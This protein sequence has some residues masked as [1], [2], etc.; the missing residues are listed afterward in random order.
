MKSILFGVRKFFVNPRIALAFLLSVIAG[1][2]NAQV[3]LGLSASVSPSTVSTG[4]TFIYTLNYQVS[5]FTTNGQNVVATLNLPE[6]LVPASTSPF[7]NSVEFDPSQV[8]GVT[9]NSGQNAIT[10]TFVNPIPA[11][12]TGQL[13]IRFRYLNGSTPNG[14]APDLFASI[15]ADN[16]LNPGGGTGPVLSN[17]LNVTAT[18]SNQH[19]ISKTKLAG[20]AIDNL[21]IY[22]INVS[23]SSPSNGSLITYQPVLVDTLPLGVEFVEATGFS[24]STVPVYNALTRTV[25]WTWLADSFR[26]N[27]SSSAY[28]SVRYTSPTFAVSDNVCNKI[29]LFGESPALPI[30]SRAAF[31]KS[32]Q[33]CFSIQSPSPGVSCYGGG[34]TAATAHW[35]N[36]HI[37]PGTSC[38][39]FSNGWYNSGNTEV[40]S[41]ELIYTVDKSIDFSTIRVRPVVD[42]FDSIAEASIEVFYATNLNGFTSAGTFLS[43]AI[44]A[45]S[46]GTLNIP[47]SLPPGE[48]VTQVKFK[49]HGPL[50]IGGSQDLSYCGDSRTAALGAKDGSP[51][52]E[53]TTYNPSNVGDDG[54][55]V[56]NNSTGSF[57]FNN[58]QTAYSA[59]NGSA[60]IMIAQ[61]VFGFTGKS[62]RNS[63]SSLR[64]SDTVYYEFSTYLGGNVNSTNVTITDTLDARLTYVPGTSFYLIDNTGSVITPTI[65]TLSPSNRQVLTYTLGTL[66]TGKTYKIRFNAVITPGTPPASITNKAWLESD[67]G[68]FNGGTDNANVSVISAVAL[69][70]YKGQTGCDP[71]YVYYPTTAIAQ[72]AGPVNYKITLKNLGNVAAKDLVMVDVFPFIGDYRGSQWFANLVGP[73]TINDPSST[74]YY[75][76]T[77]NPCFADFTPASNPPGCTNPVWTST[78]PLDITTVKAIKVTR[79]AV[80]PA[81][82]SIVL[83]W[84]MRAP[85]GTPVNL[86]MNNSIMYQVS[87][88][89]NSSQ[90]L[91]TTPIMVGMRTTCTPVLGSLGNYVWIDA[92]KNGLQDE[93]ASLGLNGMK[94]YLYGAGPDNAIGG[95]DDVLLDSTV[96]ANDFY[97]NPGYYKFI[98]LASGKYYVKFPTGYNNYLLTTTSNQAPQINGNNDAD[99]TGTSGLVT[100]D[101]SGTGVD[102]D[103][104]TIDAGYY[105]LGS[106]GNYLWVDT[107]KDGLQNDG[108]SSGINGLKVY[109]W[110]N[111]GSGMELIDSTLT[112]NDGSGNPGYYNF[113][114]DESAQ[115]QV[116]FPLNY[117]TKTL[118]TQNVSAGVNG[119]SDAN[120]A[121]GFSP[122][123]TMN[124]IV[125]T[126]VNRHNPT[127]DA[128]YRCSVAATSISGNTSICSGGQTILTSTTGVN[129]TYQWYKDGVAIPLATTSTYIANAVGAYKVTVTDSGG[130]TS[131]YSNTLNVALL[132]TPP[133]IDFSINNPVQCLPGNLFS[134]TNTSSAN[135]PS[136]NYLWSFG[137]GNTSTDSST[138]HNYPT[139]GSYSVK[140]V[141][142]NFYGCKDSVTKT[143]YAGPP[144]ADFN[145]TRNCDGTIT[146]HNNSEFANDFEWQFGNGFYCTNSTA[147]YTHEFGPGDYNVT[148]IVRNNGMCFDTITKPI[149]VAPKVEA[150]FGYDSLGCTRLIQFNNHTLGTDSVY[151]DFGVPAVSTDSS[152]SNN[153]SFVYPMDGTYT[154]KM[155]ATDSNLC[156]DTFTRV[157]HVQSLGIQ[158]TAN[159]T[160]APLAGNCVTRLKFTNTSTGTPHDDNCYWWI[161]HDGTVVQLKDASKSYPVAGVYPVKLVA[162]SSTN[163]YDTLTQLITIGS[164]SGGPLVTF[165]PLDDEQCLFGN[166]F[167]FINNSSFVGHGWTMNYHWDFGDG[168]QDLVNTFAFNKQYDTA[169]TYVVRLIGFGSNGCRD[170]AYSTVHVLPSPMLDF[171]ADAACGMD[172]TIVNHSTGSLTH[173]WDFGDNFFE[174]NNADTIY[175]SYTTQ[176]WKFI[177]LEGVHNNGCRAEIYRGLMATR[178]TRPVADFTW[179]TIP[180][181]NAIQFNNLSTGSGTYTW[182]FGDGSPISNAVNPAHAYNPAGIYQV[183]LIASNGGSCWDADTQYVKA[184][185]GING[186]LPKAAF[187]VN[188]TGCSNTVITS[189]LSTNSTWYSWYWDGVPVSGALNYSFSGALPGSHVI[190]LVARNGACYDSLSKVVIIQDIPSGSIYWDTTACSKSAVFSA[191]AANGFSYHWNFGDPGSAMDSAIGQVTSHTY[192]ANGDYIVTLTLSNTSGCSVE[193]KDTVTIAAGTGNLNAGFYYRT[194]YCNCPCNNKIQYFNISSGSASS[195]LWNFGDGS[196]STQKDPN[197]GYADTGYFNVMLT[198]FDSTGCSSTSSTQVYIPGQAHGPSASF[199]TDNPVQC[200]TGNSYNF[201]N[202]SIFL[203]SGWINKF[204]WDLGDGTIDSTHSYIFNKKYLSAGFYTVRLVVVSADGCRDTAS[205]NI[206]VVGGT[207]FSYSRPVA[208]YFP[209]K[210]VVD[211][212]MKTPGSAATGLA[213]AGVKETNEYVLFPNPTT[214]SFKIACKYLTKNTRIQVIDLLGRVMDAEVNLNTTDKLIEVSSHQ[215]SPGQYMVILH[216]QEGQTAYLRFTVTGN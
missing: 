71:E 112:A 75:T 13:Q 208:T 202:N 195:Y 49:I 140:L 95:G 178:G 43:S 73:V 35:M 177:R 11:G 122:V 1:G 30:G 86:L 194:T 100:I 7:S 175:H 63:S 168:T 156:S 44:A 92:N 129:Y 172:V 169:G 215:L 183:I 96:S 40:D 26:T 204:Y 104:T 69:R 16:N 42:G 65:T 144:V 180:C 167:N 147:D 17:I 198:V 52:V 57:F 206:Q 81:L 150:A 90:L 109:L 171:T 117:S 110:R 45:M 47:V 99:L 105:P 54:T 25:T 19:N 192:S 15:D 76:T 116:Q 3:E 56:T 214:G 97:G 148:L 80:L 200:L 145:Y 82:D 38:N 125:N 34:I 18:A 59:C 190:A 142:T 123:F 93:A 132:G 83:S 33:A 6:N 137:D 46:G 188:V 153:P 107:N 197:K 141:G 143:V 189:N 36:K 173:F 114:I 48:Y 191:Q 130:C 151:W 158:P 174:E 10:V 199:N 106:I 164:S 102:K 79:S 51:I 186:L 201:Y 27:Y 134:F 155:Y 207:C 115:Y 119:N 166:S 138:S 184:P 41:A 74:V 211:M 127:L 210:D 163:C 84:P 9:Y 89:D 60:E 181:S 135:A 31:G 136:I 22:R 55:V 87:R 23:G 70:A 72:E 160:Y 128:G 154:V 12:S 209:H 94:L 165:A 203:G 185:L 126:G 50:P 131:N 2:L 64:A 108:P 179:D 67:N 139:S 133:T 120:Q 28:I 182:Y 159:F 118:T 216:E 5:S 103:N 39:W 196:V 176:G 157:V 77:P 213:V 88:A 149:H 37:L 78:P 24:G 101:A 162:R 187:N 58:V 21:T 4:S 29:N 85:V 113:I 61:P 14:Y 124:L 121:S 152:T 68:L 212:S 146:F 8:S 91:P 170:T 205:M 32:A 111:M 98:E 20:G 62:I 66:L 53:G 161:F 193:V